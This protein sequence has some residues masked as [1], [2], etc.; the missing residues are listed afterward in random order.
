M[1]TD[2]LIFFSWAFLALMCPCYW[3]VGLWLIRRLDRLRVPLAVSVP[4]VWVALEYTR[5]HWLSAGMVLFSFA[6]LLALARLNRRSTR[7]LG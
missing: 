7:V 2:S 3:A 5:A 4:A 6:V 1:S